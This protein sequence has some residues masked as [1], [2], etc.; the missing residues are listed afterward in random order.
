ML[1]LSI[2]D[3]LDSEVSRQYPVVIKNIGN[4][5]LEYSTLLDFPTK[6]DLWINQDKLNGIIIPE[7]IDTVLLTVNTNDLITGTYVCL[8]SVF[9]ND[10]DYTSIPI[11]IFVNNIQSIQNKPN[12]SDFKLYPNPFTNQINIEFIPMGYKNI[13]LN[14]INI[15]GNYVFAKELNAQ[16]NVLNKVVISDYFDVNQLPNGIYFIQ[17]SA[18]GFQI[19]KKVIKH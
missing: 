2:I 7:H 4:K 1:P 3:T 14:I 5:N 13:R 12:I 8:F 16:S 17:I 19:T 15:F 10:D 18:S 11:E 9:E 6:S